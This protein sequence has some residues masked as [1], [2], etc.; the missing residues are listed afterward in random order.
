MAPGPTA[1]ARGA[2]D[3]ESDG[4]DAEAVARWLAETLAEAP[5]VPPAAATLIA[6]VL[7]RRAPA[8]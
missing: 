6:N 3:A 1:R 8:A 7:A 5:P 4:K 2:H